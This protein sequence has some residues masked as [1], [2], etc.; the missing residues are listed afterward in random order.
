MTNRRGQTGDS[1]IGCIL[2][3]LL[4]AAGALVAWK[5]IPVKIA[6]SEL[7]DFMVE[8]AK[9]AGRTPADVIQKRIFSK[10]S[11]LGLPIDT[12]QV[13]VEKPGDNVRMRA[14]FTVPLEFPGYTYN[15]EFDLQVERPIYIW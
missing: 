10:G 7:Y 1:K 13:T 9:W 5:A 11:E 8:Q 14:A 3:A 2:W 15:W 6:T 4:V 12:K